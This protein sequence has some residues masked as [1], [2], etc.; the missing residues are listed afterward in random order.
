MLFFFFFFLIYII[1]ILL[2]L[3]ILVF[4]TWR[5]MG[6]TRENSVNWDKQ[7]LTKVLILSF[8]IGEV[9]DLSRFKN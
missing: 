3:T 4:R 1:I 2:F 8:P 6:V 7:K 5:I 9:L